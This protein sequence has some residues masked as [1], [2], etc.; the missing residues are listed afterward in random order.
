MGVPA[1]QRT[2]DRMNFLKVSRKIRNT[3]IKRARKFPK[4]WQYY[5]ARPLVDDATDLVR[6]VRIA[7]S[8]YPTNK[9]EL[10]ERTVQFKLALGLCEAL[11]DDI[12]TIRENIH[13]TSED[14]INKIRELEK[15]SDEDKKKAAGLWKNIY[16]TYDHIEEI[17]SLIVD[18]EKLLKGVIDSDKKRKFKPLEPLKQEDMQI[19]NKALEKAWK[20]VSMTFEAQMQ[21]IRDLHENM[22]TEMAVIQRLVLTMDKIAG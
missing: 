19:R 14:E 4:S 5:L 2:D 17:A 1:S 7:N 10:E 3:V 13:V 15:G 9:R 8:I 12:E 11:S 20:E 21:L 6:K 16:V 22:S 18:E